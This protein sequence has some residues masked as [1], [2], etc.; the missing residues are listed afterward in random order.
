MKKLIKNRSL[1]LIIIIV[2]IVGLLAVVLSISRSTDDRS[3][4]QAASTLRFSPS[5]TPSNPLKAVIG[6]SLPLAVYVSPN[7]NIIS[8]VQLELTYDPGYFDPTTAVFVLDGMSPLVLREGPLY[9]PGKL[10]VSL[11]IGNNVENALKSDTKIGT[12]SLKPIN[13]TTR[14]GTSVVQFGTTT[15]ILSLG[16]ADGSQENVLAGSTPSYVN[17]TTAPRR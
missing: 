15:S 1:S 6:T 12:L 16:S 7:S 14:K 2:L 5:S 8:Y 11:D 4:A 13:K 10:I 9:E 17:I 3:R